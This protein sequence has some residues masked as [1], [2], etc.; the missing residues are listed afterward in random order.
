MTPNFRVHFV[1]KIAGVRGFSKGVSQSVD[2]SSQQAR[3]QTPN[4]GFRV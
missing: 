1:Q 3:D 2:A 4:L